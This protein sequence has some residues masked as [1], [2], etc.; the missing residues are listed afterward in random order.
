MPGWMSTTRTAESAADLAEQRFEIACSCGRVYEGLR[1]E[2]DQVLEC[3]HCGR[4][5]FVLPRSPYPDVAPAESAE[6]PAAP[7]RKSWRKRPRDASAAEPPVVAAGADTP[8]PPPGPAPPDSPEP[9]VLAERTR[10]ITP[11]RVVLVAAVGLAAATG[12]WQYERSVRNRAERAFREHSDRGYAAMEAGEFLEAYTEFRLAVE[13]LDELPRHDVKSRHVRQMH[14]ECKAA[15]D[16][17]TRPLPEILL[18]A[19]RLEQNEPVDWRRKLAQ[20]YGGHWVVLDTFVVQRGKPGPAGELVFEYPLVVGQRVVLFQGRPVVFGRLDPAKKRRRAI[21]AIEIEGIE[22][23]SDA[24]TWIVR[25]NAASA[26]LWCDYANFRA[27][28][29]GVAAETDEGID[30]EVLSERQLRALLD[31]QSRLLEVVE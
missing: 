3:N 14:R 10:L 20:F 2:T 31:E 5:L 25:V 15:S 18:E 11:L 7:P 19:E 22:L 27:L 8:E 17:I 30:G 24:K 28:G 6:P 16:L 13:A 1:A 26:F 4:R 23:S 9:L 21:L 29:F 12:Y